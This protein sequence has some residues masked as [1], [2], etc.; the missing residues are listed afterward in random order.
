MIW[1]GMKFD[2]KHMKD[3]GRCGVVS[4]SGW[5]GFFTRAFAPFFDVDIKTFTL[6]EEAEARNW[7]EKG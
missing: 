7:V 1:D 6:E 5:I 3:Y 4:D 2:F